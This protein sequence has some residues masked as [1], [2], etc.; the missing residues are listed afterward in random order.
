MLA[1]RLCAEIL[2]QRPEY[3]IN[4]ISL[5][6]P[7]STVVYDEALSSG[8]K[9]HSLGKK[10]G[11]DLIVVIRL[12]KMLLLIRPDVIH[13]H[14]AGLR[15]SIFASIFFINAVKVHTVHNIA[16]YECSKYVQYFHKLAFKYLGWQPVALSKEVKKSIHDVY[17]VNSPIVMNGIKVDES[18]NILDRDQFKQILGIPVD[19]LVLISIGRL[20]E[21]KN[22]ILL[23]DAFNEVFKKVECALLLVGEDAMGGHYQKSLKDKL[24]SFS[25]SVRSN[26]LF[27]GSRGDIPDLLNVSDVFVLSSDWEGVPL[28]LLES[29][30]A[31]VPVVCTSVGGIPDV[32]EHEKDG[33]LVPKGDKV[34]LADAILRV[35]QVELPIASLKNNAWD[36]FQQRYSIECTANGYF[37]IYKNLFT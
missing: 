3:N 8:V 37:K 32:I 31:K 26:V 16:K 4:L 19:K 13:T 6:D 35:L 27:L 5:Y 34:K 20:C 12:L 14:L 21:Q 30:G 25:E 17:G 10:K 22:Q 9:I 36:K 15:Y 11:F 29:M 2:R 1:V 7:I 18:L 23:L 28:T 33:L 24:S